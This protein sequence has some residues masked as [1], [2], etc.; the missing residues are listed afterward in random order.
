VKLTL[1]LLRRCVKSK[2]GNFPESD[3]GIWVRKAQ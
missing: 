3:R 2:R 1:G